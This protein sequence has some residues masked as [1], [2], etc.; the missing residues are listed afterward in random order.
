MQ[1][2]YY[3]NG[4]PVGCQTL[5]PLALSRQAQAE[6][7]REGG[8]PTVTTCPT[9]DAE[10]ELDEFDVDKGDVISCPDCGVELEVVGL[11]P[12]ELDVAAHEEDDDDWG[13]S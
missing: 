12:I 13:D 7:R 6:Q 1:L 10:I 3:Q 8:A 9:C 4:A 2:G 5:R 11:S